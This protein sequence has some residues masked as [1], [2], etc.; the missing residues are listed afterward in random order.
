M[1]T[2]ASCHPGITPFTAKVAGRAARVRAVELRSIQQFAAILYR[3]GVGGCDRGRPCGRPAKMT[4]YSR[5]E[6][7]RRDAFSRARLWAREILGRRLVVRGS[8]LPSPNATKSCTCLAARPGWFSCPADH[9]SSRRANGIYADL[10]ADFLH[11]A[12]VRRRSD[13]TNSRSD[14]R[15]G[16]AGGRTHGLARGRGR[17]CGR[18]RGGSLGH[19]QKARLQP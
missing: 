17:R 15:W 11:R 19:G 9:P 3:H 1:S 7:G 16:G 10:I 4:L 5:P 8:R 13:R 2:N 18:R 12:S 14:R 6:A